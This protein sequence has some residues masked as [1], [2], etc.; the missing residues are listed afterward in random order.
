MKEKIQ[1]WQDKIF[2]IKLKGLYDKSYFYVTKTTF[3][4]LWPNEDKNQIA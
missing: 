1:K 3:S 4:F 2:P